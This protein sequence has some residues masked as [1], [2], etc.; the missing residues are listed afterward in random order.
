M[1]TS[2]SV[3]AACAHVVS[4]AASIRLAEA[5][6]LRSVLVQA[7]HAAASES[8]FSEARSAT[9]VVVNLNGALLGLSAVSQRRVPSGWPACRSP[10]QK[11]PA[12]LLPLEC[13]QC[14]S[15]SEAT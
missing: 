9:G 8:S 11:M 6:F 3:T 12:A 2:C 1:H 15:L 13:C 7:A 5:A 4:P 10:R 14:Q